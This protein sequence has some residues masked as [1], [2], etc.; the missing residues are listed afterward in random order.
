MIILQSRG[1]DVTV[2]IGVDAI[3]ITA[4]LP[5]ELELATVDVN[6][7]TG[8]VIILVQDANARRTV[9]FTLGERVRNPDI[10][11]EVQVGTIARIGP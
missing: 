7:V 4:G 1:F 9:K 3:T 5:V 8:A 11:G 2:Q 10:A 6:I